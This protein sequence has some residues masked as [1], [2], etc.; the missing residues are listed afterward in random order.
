[1]VGPNKG[2]AAEGV[3]L[4]LASDDEIAAAAARLA[5]A[6]ARLTEFRYEMLDHPIAGRCLRNYGLLTE[7]PEVASRLG[8]TADERFWS[9][10]YWFARF[11]REWQAAVGHDAGLEQQVFKLLESPEHIPVA[12]DPL[13]E[14]E[15]AVER[16]AV[17]RPPG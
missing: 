17:V 14:V 4:R 16:D 10:Y 8:L 7:Y 6:E 15:A 3:T 11:A 12:Y 2:L 1:L 5:E 9:R 13:P